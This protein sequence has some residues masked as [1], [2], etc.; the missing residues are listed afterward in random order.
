MDVCE[1]NGI[2]GTPIGDQAWDGGLQIAGVTQDP[3]TTSF[4]PIS[5]GL[6]QIP[7]PL[8]NELAC[9]VNTVALGGGL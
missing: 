7:N 5:S 6:T 8:G 3:G 4:G 1:S 2:I 9:D